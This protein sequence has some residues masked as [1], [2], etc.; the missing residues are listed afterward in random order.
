[1]DHRCGVTVVEPTTTARRGQV[2]GGTSDAG[3]VSLGFE[4]Y[5]KVMKGRLLLLCLVFGLVAC[6]RKRVEPASP[7][8]PA[9]VE[10]QVDGQAKQV[11]PSATPVTPI[12]REVAYR[13]GAFKRWSLELA[14]G[15]CYLIST[16]GDETVELLYVRLW[17]P[18]GKRLVKTQQPAPGLV[19]EHCPETTGTYKLEVK[20]PKGHGHYLTRVFSKEPGAPS[21][22]AAGP[23]PVATEAA[24]PPATTAGTTPPAPVEGGIAARIAT[25]GSANEGAA[26]LGELREGAGDLTDWYVVLEPAKC[27]WFIVAG[28][29]G[30]ER[31]S[32]FAWD[33][34]KKRVGKAK[35][36]GPDAQLGHCPEAGGMYRV[37]A[38]V[39]KG[40]GAYALGVYAK[41][42]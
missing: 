39:A 9:W 16:A 19:F 14:Q 22:I 23:P 4:R 5:L 36:E 10:Q 15:N 41:A 20:I 28:G 13:R 31:I 12:F 24:P 7:A 17:D 30:V 18:R 3:L 27:Y 8:A 25:M 40:E 38:K 29:E 32:L 1:M 37:Q 2:E 35:A 33:P 11:A 6:K 34:N 26:P 21:A 42:R